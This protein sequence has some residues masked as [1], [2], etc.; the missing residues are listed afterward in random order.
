MH[1]SVVGY[2]NKDR[3]KRE[4]K[5]KVLKVPAHE[6]SLCNDRYGNIPYTSNDRPKINRALPNLFADEDNTVFCAGDLSSNVGTCPG[7]SGMYFKPF[8]TN[9]SF[10]AHGPGR[11]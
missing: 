9:L 5:A 6:K 7:D 1:L 3:N 2:A 10:D 11:D 8:D 4:L